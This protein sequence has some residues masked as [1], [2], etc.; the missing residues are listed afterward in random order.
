MV[1]NVNECF[2]LGSHFSVFQYVQCSKKARKWSSEQL[3]ELV[4][5]TKE[6]NFVEKEIPQFVSEFI[7]KTQFGFCFN[8]KIIEKGSKTVLL[9][10]HTTKRS[11]K[12]KNA[13]IFQQ[14]RIELRLLSA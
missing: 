14:I 12:V 9:N 2:L 1:G 3:I 8:K 7:Q 4:F 6:L 11:E 13:S 5:D 10:H